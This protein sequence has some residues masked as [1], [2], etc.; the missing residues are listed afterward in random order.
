MQR[1]ELKMPCCFREP[2]VKGSEAVYVKQSSEP[3][4]LAAKIARSGRSAAPTVAPASGRRDFALGQ[5]VQRASKTTRN[6]EYNRQFS[7]LSVAGADEA[8]LDLFTSKVSTDVSTGIYASVDASGSEVSQDAPVADGEAHRADSK[9]HEMLQDIHFKQAAG[10]TQM[11]MDV[12]DNLMQQQTLTRDGDGSTE[13]LVG[14]KIGGG[15]FGEVFQGLYRGKSVAVK[16]MKIKGGAREDGEEVSE[17]PYKEAAIAGVCVHPNIVSTIYSDVQPIFDARQDGYGGAASTAAGR[18]PVGPAASVK[19]WQVRMVM[20]RCD[21]GS[22]RD[23]VSY[24]AS[25][26]HGPLHT[27]VPLKA[28]TK[29]CDRTLCALLIARDVAKGIKLLHKYKILHGDLKPHNV[30]LQS[31]LEDPRGF[32]AKLSDFGLSI[33]M[34]AHDGNASDIKYGTVQYLSAEVLRTHIMTKKADVYSFG[35]IMWEVWHSKLFA[36]FYNVEKKKR[37]KGQ[38]MDDYR[39]AISSKCPKDYKALMM[40]CWSSRPEKRPDFLYGD[41]NILEALDCM[42]F[43]LN[44]RVYRD[45]QPQTLEPADDA[46]VK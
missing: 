30:L 34:A 7:D 18:H 38:S 3:A 36:E 17:L 23:W 46:P 13:L 37:G 35:I 21:M 40:R 15:G 9:E 44:H 42:I 12:K 27:A 10:I 6:A 11:L 29:A 2:P 8:K 4:G 19:E 26:A 45:T 20:E 43:N 5:D 24:A 22:V 41:I 14:E 25:K 33:K 32:V 39:P 31:S 1:E 28:G 16:I